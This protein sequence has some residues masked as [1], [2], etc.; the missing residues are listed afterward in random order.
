MT[1]DSTV[2]RINPPAA[3]EML[4]GGGIAFVVIFS[5]GVFLMIVP[6]VGWIAGPACMLT[7]ALILIAHVA[8]VMKSKPNYTG[9]CPYCGAEA[10]A[11]EPGSSARCPE[12][13]KAFAHQNGQLLKLEQ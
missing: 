9:H 5:V 13:K 1:I 8:G 2:K 12:C 11:G 10:P 7:A 3:I 6:I 4:A